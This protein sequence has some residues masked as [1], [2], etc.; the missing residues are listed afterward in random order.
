MGEWQL[1]LD[2]CQ[3]ALA[4]E[5]VELMDLKS[6]P[7]REGERYVLDNKN[8]EIVFTQGYRAVSWHDE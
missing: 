8:S 4:L 7:G 2:E 1:A 5:G 6:F 3:K